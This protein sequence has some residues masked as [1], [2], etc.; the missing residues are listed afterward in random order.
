M[1][2]PDGTV[3]VLLDGAVCGY[4][5]DPHRLVTALR[6]HK[7]QHRLWCEVAYAGQ[8]RGDATV[9]IFSGVARL[10]R[11]V[12]HLASGRIEY[13]G[14]S[15]R[16]CHTRRTRCH[17]DV[18]RAG[19]AHPVQRHEP[20]AAQ[21][22]SVSDGQAGHGHARAPFCRPIRRQ[23]VPTADTAAP[24][25]VQRYRGA[26]ATG[27]AL[28]H[29]FQ[30]GGGGDILHRLRYGGRHGDE[31]G[32]LGARARPRRGVQQPAGGSGA[33]TASGQYRHRC[34]LCIVAVGGRAP[35]LGRRAVS[36]ERPSSTTTI[37]RIGTGIRGC[38]GAGRVS[39][40]RR[41]PP[42]HTAPAG[43]RRQVRLAPRPEGR[44]VGGVA[45][46]GHAL[47]RI[48]HGAGYCVQPERLPVAHDHRHDGGGDGWQGVCGA[49]AP[50]RR[51]HPVWSCQTITTAAPIA[52]RRFRARAAGGRLR[53]PRH[54][55]PVQRLLRRAVPGAH[56][57]R[58]DRLAA[59]AT[60]R[61][62]QVSGARTRTGESH[63]ST[64]AERAQAG[65][66]HPLRRDGTR[67]GAGLRG[68]I[69]AAG[70]PATR[71]RPAHHVRECSGRFAT[72]AAE[73]AAHPS[74]RCGGTRGDRAHCGR[75]AGAAGAPAV[76]VQVS[77]ARVG[78]DEH[79]G[80]VVDGVVRKRRGI[81][82]RDSR[83]RYRWR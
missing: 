31:P 74:G 60:S 33:A 70:P 69:R 75:V 10:L 15:S 23:A 22:V 19:V 66:R 65:R 42:A 20:I 1:R 57:H 44:A 49:R 11:P 48:G 77:G 27:R 82:N 51:R 61:R 21:H 13:I 43:H 36:G 38:G 59:A 56:L 34:R 28:R 79:P 50:A 37:H 72:G 16:R 7:R 58:G 29:Q 62:R 52:C 78:G 4:C 40:P 39:T 63:L 83:W 3:P 25:G 32:Q 41:H 17:G 53:V 6:Q 45:G 67:C 12:R 68:G 64:A 54:R 71:F 55:A 8:R 14:R 35:A 47:R 9:W 2:P 18:E 73:C 76:R 30:C 26:A 46:G 5:T 24:A 80:D 81:Y